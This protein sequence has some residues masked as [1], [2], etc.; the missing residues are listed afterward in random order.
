M[1]VT[2]WALNNR[3]PGWCKIVKF[4]SRECF[5]PNNQSPCFGLHIQSQDQQQ[6]KLDIAIGCFKSIDTTHA[7]KFINAI[8]ITNECKHNQT[9]VSV[10]CKLFQSCTWRYYPVRGNTKIRLVNKQMKSSPTYKNYLTYRESN[11]AK[12]PPTCLI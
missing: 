9:Q 5:C 7:E 6:P 10:I 4:P 8:L 3:P 11:T 1:V 2:I 12:A